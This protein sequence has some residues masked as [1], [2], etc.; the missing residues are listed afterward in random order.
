MDLFTG[1]CLRHI[2]ARA[3]TGNNSAKLL[4]E[5]MQCIYLYVAQTLLLTAAVVPGLRHRA[6]EHKVAG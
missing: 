5:S 1:I 4:D 3:I 6:L 2:Y